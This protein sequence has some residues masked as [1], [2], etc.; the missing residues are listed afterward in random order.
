[1]KNKRNLIIGGIGILVLAFVFYSF[2]KGND[3]TPIKVQAIKV[4]KGDVTTLV[5]ATGTV[6][7]INQ[8]EVGTQVS[9]V[10]EKI[11]GRLQQCRNR[12]TTNSRIG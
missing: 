12:R 2:L 6:E 11:Y 3:E 7:P 9:G 4:K 5:T 1:M 10:I 8:V